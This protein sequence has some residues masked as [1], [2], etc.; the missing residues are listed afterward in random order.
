MIRFAWMIILL[1]GFEEC[2][3]PTPSQNNAVAKLYETE[4]F[5]NYWYSGT[6]EI[7]SYKLDQ[8]RYGENRAGKAML[9]F[10]TE[11]FSRKKQVKLDEPTAAGEGK[12]SV[13]KMNFTKNFVT[14]I[15]PYSMM[16]SVFSPISRNVQPH[17]LKVTMSSQ[18]WCGQV[19]SQM[20]LYGKKFE[21]MG[22]SYFEQEGESKTS[23]AATWL[24]DELWNVI[25]LDPENLP[26]GNVEIIPGLFFTRLKHT[27]LKLLKATI[28]K[29]ENGQEVYYSINLPEQQRRLVIR[30]H[31][32]FPH[33]ILGWVESFIERGQ[34]QQTSAVLDK[35]IR[36]DYWKKNKNEFRYLRDSL[37]LSPTNF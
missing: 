33:K 13:L 31:K 11:D 28:D 4:S 24:E 26:V 34:N 16:L 1:V 20:N 10:V 12:V 29:S 19:F 37:G 2:S 21:I 15:Y 35:T 27:D 6:A 14:G 23:L 25:R 22:H 3:S 17:P 7:S 32:E 18:E 36:I 9:I 8:S 5:K 30:Y